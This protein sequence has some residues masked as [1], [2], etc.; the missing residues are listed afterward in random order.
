M[1]LHRGC[2]AT[3]EAA[4]S[5]LLPQQAHLSLH[6]LYRLRRDYPKFIQIHRLSWC[7]RLLGSQVPVRCHLN[8]IPY[9]FRKGDRDCL[10]TIQ[11]PFMVGSIT[12]FDNSVHLCAHPLSACP[13]FQSQLIYTRSHVICAGGFIE[14]GDITEGVGREG[15][16][17]GSALPSSVT[18]VNCLGNALSKPDQAAGEKRARL[19]QRSRT[20]EKPWR[21]AANSGNIRQ[22]QCAPSSPKEAMSH[23][24][25]MAVGCIP[26][27]PT[28]R[29]GVRGR[30][31]FGTQCCRWD[32]WAGQSCQ[33]ASK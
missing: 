19:H 3:S 6:L 5:L 16:G 30:K 14:C 29:P 2:T 32:R 22:D 26:R 20:R 10:S 7:R 8:R 18:E 23:Y 17:T 28:A 24:C 21:V 13:V 12:E 11:D 31:G 15:R 4:R 9:E 1:S 27:I 33:A 25:S